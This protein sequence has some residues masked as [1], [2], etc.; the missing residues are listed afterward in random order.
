MRRGRATSDMGDREQ[1]LQRARLAEQAE[2]Y[3]DMASAMK[4]VRAPGARAAGRGARRGEGMD[5]RAASP[6]GPGA[7]R[8]GA[9]ARP[10]TVLPAPAGRPAI[11]CG[12]TRVGSPGREPLGVAHAAL[13]GR[14]GVCVPLRVGGRGSPHPSSEPCWGEGCQRKREADTFLLLEHSSR[15]RAH[16]LLVFFLN[17]PTCNKESPS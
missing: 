16:S 7:T 1:L 3:D 14:T 9:A 4:A 15:P 2:R 13:L 8:L 6:S 5:G 11:S 10:S 17:T 12:R